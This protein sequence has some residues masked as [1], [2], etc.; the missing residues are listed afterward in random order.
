[1]FL[2]EGV[3]G[4]LRLLILVMPCWMEVPWVLTVLNMF[5]DVL[6]HCPIEKDPIM[7]V[8]VGHVLKGLPYLHLT[9]WLLRGVCYK[10]RDSLPQYVRKWWGHLEHLQ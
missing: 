1:M 8:L 5:A 2:A 3:K 9:L 4:Q 7:D 10:D 6:Q